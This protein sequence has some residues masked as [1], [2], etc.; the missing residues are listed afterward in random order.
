M[1]YSMDR[2]DSTLGP[3]STRTPYSFLKSDVWV[4]TN[5]VEIWCEKLYC[6]ELG[7]A[8]T[9]CSHIKIKIK[10]H[11]TIIWVSGCDQI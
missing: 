3:Q 9:S 6:Q 10:I 2:V 5:E 11:I 4:V 8:E 1:R 7:I